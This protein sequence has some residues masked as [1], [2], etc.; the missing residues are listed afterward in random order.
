[1]KVKYQAKHLARVLG[2]IEDFPQDWRGKMIL[3]R[4][5]KV[6]LSG[7]PYRGANENLLLSK[8]GHLLDD[9]IR[10]EL[11]RR[12]ERV[13]RWCRPLSAVTKLLRRLFSPTP[14]L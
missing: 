2:L 5:L 9:R 1:M 6:P 3:A 14:A 12:R 13:S 10:G 8:N 4:E 11:T 7:L